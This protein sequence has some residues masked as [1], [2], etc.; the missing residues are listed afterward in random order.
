MRTNLKLS[1]IATGLKHK[2]LAE[3]ANEILPR[4][5][6]LSE[7]DLT[8]LITCRMDPTAEQAAALSQI[9]GRPTFELFAPGGAK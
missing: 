2:A 4:H 8:K 5:E 7:H 3:R 9:F 6:Q 1:I